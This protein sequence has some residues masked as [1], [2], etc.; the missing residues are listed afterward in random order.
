MPSRRRI[1]D[2]A[3]GVR[4]SRGRIMAQRISN[5][6]LVLPCP[7]LLLPLVVLLLQLMMLELLMLLLCEDLR[8]PK[9]LSGAVMPEHITAGR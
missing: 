1:L 6:G 5:L 8:Q 4:A 2:D 7:L 3:L 9:S